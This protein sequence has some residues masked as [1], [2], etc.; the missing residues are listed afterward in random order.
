MR[1]RRR[2]IPLVLIAAATGLWIGVAFGEDNHETRTA[3]L[4]QAPQVQPNP[5]AIQLHVQS[6]VLPSSG[7]HS[8]IKRIKTIAPQ[9]E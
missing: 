1:R 8:R 3:Q 9:V 2:F 6:A 7:D 4:S 5:Q